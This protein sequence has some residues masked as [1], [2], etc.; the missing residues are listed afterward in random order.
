[1]YNIFRTTGRKF[2]L[3]YHKAVLLCLLPVLSLFGSGCG[4]KIKIEQVRPL[5]RPAEISVE[6]VDGLTEDFL[7]GVDVSTALVQEQSGVVYYN[8][9]GIE[10]DI[11][12][13]LAENGVNT[14]RLRVW[15][16]PYDS[17]DNGYG[18]G[19]NDL[20]TAIELGKR[21]TRYG[22]GVI[23]DFHYS[24]FWADPSKQ[25]VPKAWEDMDLATKAEALYTYTRESMEA[26]LEE[27][28]DVVLVQIGNETTT[29]M[30]GETDWSAICTLMTQGSLAVRETAAKY[31]KE[32]LV[33]L[34]FANPEHSGQYAS[35][36]N[37]LARHNVD[38]DVFITSYYPYWHGTLENL[39]TV[40]GHISA[41]Y[42]KKVMVGEISWPYTLLDGDNS[43][44]SVSA[45]SG[46]SLSY[47]VSVQGQADCIRDTT[48]ALASLGD[49][50]IGIC[51]WEPAW[52]PVPGNTKEERMILWETYGSGWATSFAGSYDPDDAGMYYGGSAWDNQA[53]FDYHGKPLAS[54]S[55]FRYLTTGTSDR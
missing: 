25:M 17:D 37:T 39:T 13:T 14:I 35:Y 31:K 27:E 20:A 21:A 6:P 15:N 47:S 41:N 26:L 10:Q 8:E 29:G 28:I 50:A 32:I 2:F 51:Y 1:M 44:N 4:Q 24:D 22:L 12:K 5:N 9:D 55:V 34:H 36:A 45:Y 23:I 19:N 38:Y 49:A 46:V 7:L 48:A 43:G 11:M 53:L 54:L 3:G 18:G 52:I 33:G 30:A 16:D 40:L 42:N